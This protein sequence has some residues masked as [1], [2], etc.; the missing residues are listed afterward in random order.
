MP[1]ERIRS[2]VSSSSSTR[3]AKRESGSPKITEPAST[4]QRRGVR[5]DHL[6]PPRQRVALVFPLSEAAAAWTASADSGPR[7][8]LVPG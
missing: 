7:V 2:A 8:V 6:S 5:T 4:G 3:P 1:G